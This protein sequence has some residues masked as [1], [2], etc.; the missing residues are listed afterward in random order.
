MALQRGYFNDSEQS[1]SRQVNSPR[2]DRTTMDFQQ[3][4]S[5]Q[6]LRIYDQVRN[7]YPQG[8]GN[9][10]NAL[11]PGRLVTYFQPHQCHASDTCRT[12]KG[13][14]RQAGSVAE[15]ADAPAQGMPA[16]HGDGLNRRAV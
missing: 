1:M 16:L 10:V 14:L 2:H 6:K 15:P 4:P 5:A 9:W 11:V 13:I 3:Q 8:K 12:G 7:V